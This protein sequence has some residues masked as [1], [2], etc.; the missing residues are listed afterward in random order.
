MTFRYQ[1]R[2][3]VQLPFPAPLS[4]LRSPLAFKVGRRKK[5]RKNR[6]VSTELRPMSEAEGLIAHTTR[7]DASHWPL[8]AGLMG[9]GHGSSLG[10]W[11]GA[12]YSSCRCL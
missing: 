10:R 5:K 9:G 2:S 6:W 12:S 4:S 11:V 1:H 7:A 3:R 8:A